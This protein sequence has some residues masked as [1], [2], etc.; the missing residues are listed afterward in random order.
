MLDSGLTVRYE[1]HIIESIL[2]IDILE[3]VNAV[4]ALRACMRIDAFEHL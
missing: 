3:L 1:D 2:F 4:A